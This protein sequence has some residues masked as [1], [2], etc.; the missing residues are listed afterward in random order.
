MSNCEEESILKQKVSN[1]LS[2]LEEW[3]V[4][5]EYL[6]LDELIWYLYEST[7]FYDYILTSPNGMLKTANLKLLFEKARDYE[8]ASFPFATG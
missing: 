3:Q 5:E 8:K 7:G 1:F 2:M 4:K 6:S